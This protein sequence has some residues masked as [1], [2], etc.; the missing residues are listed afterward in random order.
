MWLL[1]RMCYDFFVCDGGRFC[2]FVLLLCLLMVAFFF[3]FLSRLIVRFFFCLFILDLGSLFT[4]T[5]AF[6]F[7]CV[8]S[9]F[10][11]D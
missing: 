9:L 6:P 4:I 7:F 1:W 5:V 3:S 11:L 10:M 8:M 2:F